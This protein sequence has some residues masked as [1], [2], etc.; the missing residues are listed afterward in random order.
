MKMKQLRE[1]CTPMRAFFQSEK[2]ALRTLQLTDLLT[3]SAERPQNNEE[4]TQVD[5]EQDLDDSDDDENRSR[6]EDVFGAEF[7]G[8]PA[9]P[10]HQS[11]PG[12]SSTGK[13]KVEATR[14]ESVRGISAASSF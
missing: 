12:N 11:H 7:A 6:V 9:P 8:I 13:R 2:E 4:T 14:R 1:T 5:Y 3:E 10:P